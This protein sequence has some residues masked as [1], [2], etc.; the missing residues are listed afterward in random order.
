MLAPLLACLGLS[1]AAAETTTPCHSYRFTN[2]KGGMELSSSIPP[3]AANRGY[4]CIGT[5]GHVIRVVPP[6]LS[7][8]E[9]E[10]RDHDDASKKAAKEAGLPRQRSDEE[11][12]NLYASPCDV[13]AA[14]TRKILSIENEI[15][16]TR[17]N[18][19]A[20]KQKKR[21]LETQA[22]DREREGLPPAA[23]ILDNLKIL[24]TQI[25][26]AQQTI[27]TRQVEKQHAIGQFD[28]DLEGMKRLQPSAH[29][30]H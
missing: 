7:P 23:D 28:L 29:C 6:K 24:E 17:E 8:A 22:A 20:R 4:A 19:E 14:R 11:L 10:Q 12:Q 3:E 30:A 16:A 21:D 1:V 25:A 5:D 13:E 27:E 18:I 26:E 15:K 9:Q 2:E